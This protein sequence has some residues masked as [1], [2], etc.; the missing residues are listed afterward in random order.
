MERGPRAR[1]LKP[2]YRSLE[3]DALEVVREPPGAPEGTVPSP[4]TERIPDP[5]VPPPGESRDRR[6][7]RVRRF[8]RSRAPR[9]I[10]TVHGSATETPAFP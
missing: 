3:V 2:A 4:V 10:E 7:E 1:Q 6:E 9:A 5:P 8:L